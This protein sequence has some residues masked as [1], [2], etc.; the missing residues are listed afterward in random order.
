MKWSIDMVSDSTLQPT[1]KRLLL[2][3]FWCSI[4]EE[5]PQLKDYSNTPPFSNYL[6]V[7]GQIFLHLLQP[8]QHISTDWMQKQIWESSRLPLQ[9]E[10]KEIWDFPG[11]PVVKT[12]PSS[13]GG[14]GSI[15][16]QGA[17]IPHALGPK[18]RSIKQ[19]KYCNKF[20]KDLKKK[21]GLHQKNFLKKE[22]D[23]PKCQTCHSSSKFLFSK[24]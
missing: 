18:N 20:N 17:K 23:L 10:N 5:Y 24:K 1:F 8:K 11:G 7:W 16:G 13:E 2:V 6:S 21:N 9:P 19:K 4:R 15:P 22:R 12:P 3:E 14:T